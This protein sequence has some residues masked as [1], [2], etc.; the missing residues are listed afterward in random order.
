VKFLGEEEE[1]LAQYCKKKL[2]EKHY[3]FFVFGHR[4][5]PLE[6]KLS[7]D[8]TYINTGDWITHFS[9][10]EFDGEQL[11]LKKYTE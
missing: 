6:I 9:Y 2:K 10:G 8:S 4:H 7:K 11:L 1:W 3:N 5:L